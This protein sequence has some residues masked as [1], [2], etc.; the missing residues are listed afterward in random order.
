MANQEGQV[1]SQNDLEENVLSETP[2]GYGDMK[3]VPVAESIRYRKRAQ[4]AE[5]ANESLAEQLAK[6]K[7]EVSEL[8][9]QLRNLEIEQELTRKLT[10]AGA[11]DLETSLLLA[12]ARAERLENADLDG[13]VTQLSK[14]K[15]YLFGRHQGDRHSIPK[16]ANVKERREGGQTALERAAKKA[17]GTGNRTDLQ[18]YLKLRRR[19]V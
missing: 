14:E 13:I 7:S 9:G 6:A 19:F 18:E 2:A 4:A 12:K 15:Q 3:L 11:V 5:K 17:A 1:M 16:T 8:A 10:S